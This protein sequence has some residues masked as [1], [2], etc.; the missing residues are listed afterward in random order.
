M[1]IQTDL[2]YVRMRKSHRRS[3]TT[4]E[5]RFTDAVTLLCYGKKPSQKAVREWLR[6]TSDDLQAFAS[7][8]GPEWA[9]GIVLLDAAAVLADTPEEGVDHKE[10][11]YG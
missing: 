8:N 11:P 4:Y 1:S 10:N 6:K 7:D 5:E 2:G 9:Q 3:P